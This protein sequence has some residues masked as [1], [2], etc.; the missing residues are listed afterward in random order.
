MSSAIEREIGSAGGR[1]ANNSLQDAF[2]S[3]G[4]KIVCNSS[5]GIEIAALLHWCACA[6]VSAFVVVGVGTKQMF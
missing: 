4:L 2:T 6:G 1:V 5:H 3:L